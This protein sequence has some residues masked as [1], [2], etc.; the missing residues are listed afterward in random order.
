MALCFALASCL[1]AP[2]AQQI[3]PTSV[4]AGLKAGE[5]IYTRQCASCHDGGAPQ[6]PRRDALARLPAA[7]IE[8]ALTT[9]VMQTQAAGLSAAERRSVAEFLSGEVARSKDA[10]AATAVRCASNVPA[11]NMPLR[12]ADWGMDLRNLRAVGSATTSIDSSNVSRLKLAWAFAFPG[13]TRAR[14]QPTVAGTTVFTADQNGVVYALDAASGCILWQVQSGAEIRSSLIIEADARGAARRLYFGD[15]AGVVHALDI[16]SRTIVWSTRPDPHPQATI[17][18]APRLVGGKLIVGVSSLEVVAAMTPTY[19]CCTFRGA[20]AALDAASGRVIWKTYTIAEAPSQQGVNSAAAAQ[21]GPSGAPV[22]ATPTIDTE[23][24]RIYVGTGE[25]YSHPSSDMSDSIL[26]LDLTTGKK[27][28]AFQARAKDVWNA[29]CP[30]GANCPAGTGPDYDFGA[31]PI[32]VRLNSGRSLILAGQK[33]GELY[34]LDPDANG[35]VVWKTKP[36]RG[37]IMGGVHWGMTSDG[38]RVY[39]PISL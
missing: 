1:A 2:P 17:T 32:L 12:V 21:F 27:V 36:G 38:A 13:G 31:P 29:S 34:A 33:S 26:A 37:G 30:G 22:W 3:T 10:P 23:R 24:N 19:A 11:S 25:N 8:A 39:V 9:G 20:V 14:V 16:A 15:L 28:W 6:A 35:A 5:N 18:G 7:R 4:E